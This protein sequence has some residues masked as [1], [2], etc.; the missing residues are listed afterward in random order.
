MKGTVNG[1]E[2]IDFFCG[3]VGV[4]KKLHV[5]DK[6]LEDVILLLRCVKTDGPSL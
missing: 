6:L 2:E 3:V 5:D 4:Q 1:H